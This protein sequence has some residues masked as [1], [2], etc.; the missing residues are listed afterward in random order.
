MRADKPGKGRK[1]TRSKVHRSVVWAGRL[2][3]IIVSCLSLTFLA[4]LPSTGWL[5]S[6]GRHPMGERLAREK[7]SLHF[8]NGQFQN[9]ERIP[10]L[11]HGGTLYML[12]QELFGTAE[13]VPQRPIPVTTRIAADYRLQPSSG[14]RATWMG[15]ATVLLEID[16][17]RV[18][19]DPIWSDRCS[20]STLVGPKRFFPPPIPM[21]QLPPID[22][23]LISHDHYDHL[24]MQTVKAL[25]ARGT[26]FAV[27]LGVGSHLDAWGV[28]RSQIFEFDRGDRLVL[29][30]LTLVATPAHHYS[31]RNPFHGNDTL[32]TSWAVIGPKH[33]VFFSSDSGYFSGFRDVAAKEGPFDLALIK[34]GA[35]DPTWED[36]H[37]TPEQAVQVTIDVGAKLMLPVHW[38]TF[39]LAF[40]AW[41]EP[42]DRVVAAAQAA[43]IGLFIPK[44]GQFIEPSNLPQQEIWW[45]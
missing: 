31:G 45:R 18:L 9:S 33:R 3:L 1:R 41:N 14:L 17:Q 38:G 40:H 35:S 20:P 42:V 5:A 44:P 34:I 25:S 7:R 37:M 15:H 6:F 36:I 43:Q 26:K 16:G 11:I 28:P 32:W 8:L 13:T 2:L 24:D 22:V 4:L 29:G 12:R 21:S 39:K 19:T 10:N 30:D 23:V 27:P